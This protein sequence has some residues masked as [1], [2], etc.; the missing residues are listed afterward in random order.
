LNLGIDFQ[1]RN[2]TISG[3]IELYRKRSSNLI[4]STE[5]DPTTGITNTQSNSASLSGKGVE[6]NINSINSNRLFKWYTNLSFSHITNKIVDYKLN[7]QLGTV[8]NLISQNGLSPDGLKGK[9]PYSLYSLPFAGLDPNTGDPMGYLGKTIS[10]DYLAILNQRYDTASLVFHGTTLPPYF[11]FLNNIFECKGISVAVSLSYRFGY[12][13]RKQTINYF[14][15]YRRGVTHPDFAKRW[16]NPGDE[17]TTTIPSMIYPLSNSR[18]DDFYA[19]SS[20]N[21]LKGDHIRLQYIKVSYRINKAQW[22]KLPANNIE[23]YINVTNIGILWRANKEH[24]DPD[25]Q[26]GNTLFPQPKSLAIGLRLNF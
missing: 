8:R 2:N 5:I 24:L 1:S 22:K 12:Y 21:V 16:I 23:F 13:F 18:R 19:G 7:D 15:L 6:V 20:V 17:M 26:G 4:Y 14:N 11:G 9:P 10:K 25:F 3:S